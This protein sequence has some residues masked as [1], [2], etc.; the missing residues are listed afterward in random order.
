MNRLKRGRNPKSPDA[1]K[2]KKKAD[3][4]DP[5]S[6]IM[7]NRKGFIQAYNCQAACTEEESL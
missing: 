2:I 7:K 4:T 1:V 6:R 5:E 3:I